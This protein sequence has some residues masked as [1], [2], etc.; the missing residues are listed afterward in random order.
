MNIEHA[1]L[2]HA[3]SVVACADSLELH[4][5]FAYFLFKDGTG[6]APA[7]L[8]IDTLKDYKALLANTYLF[9]N[10][11]IERRESTCQTKE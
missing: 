4:H 3:Y 5:G 9:I 10:K 2:G 1:I 7:D 6:V 8:D 11:E